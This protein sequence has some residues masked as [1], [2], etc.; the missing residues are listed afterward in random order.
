MFVPLENKTFFKRQSISVF[1]YRSIKHPTQEFSFLFFIDVLGKMR[2]NQHLHTKSIIYLLCVWLMYQ[3]SEYIHSDVT[4]GTKHVF[5]IIK[6]KLQWSSVY[7][8]YK[9]T[10]IQSFPLAF[11][12]PSDL[13][14]L[15]LILLCRV[16][17]TNTYRI[18]RCVIQDDVQIT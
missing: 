13:S 6:S 4:M 8:S 16:H 7:K 1:N 3:Y 12:S 17:S 5:H 15:I 18:V 10:T 2:S 9:I 11:T 14:T